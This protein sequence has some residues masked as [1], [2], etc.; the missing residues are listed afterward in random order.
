MDKQK[1]YFR[2]GPSVESCV[3][4]IRD[5]IT[6]QVE[7]RFTKMQSSFVNKTEKNYFLDYCKFLWEN[8]KK[9]NIDEFPLIDSSKISKITYYKTKKSVKETDF[10]SNLT[11]NSYN[12]FDF[13]VSEET[14]KLLLEFKLPIYNKIQ[15][16][17]PE[18]SVQKE[19]FLLGFPEM[20]L[21]N[22]DYGHSVILDSFSGKQL[23]FKSF[24]EYINRTYK[25]TKLYTIQLNVDYKYDIIRLQNTGI[26]FSDSLID[27]L[28]HHN[29]TGLDYLSQTLFCSSKII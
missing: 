28:K 23:K 8:R 1:R 17:I 6:N 21:E 13:I 18:F 15:V 2:V 3:T 27:A 12:L 7:T 14:H 22:V 19:Y 4:G 5:G 26:F 20:S 9:I 11:D 25:F 16:I 10:I 29:I 24:E